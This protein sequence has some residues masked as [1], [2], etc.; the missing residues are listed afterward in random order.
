[1]A[2]AV[3][4][5]PS[6][7]VTDIPDDEVP[8]A[9]RVTLDSLVTRQHTLPVTHIPLEGDAEPPDEDALTPEQQ[10]AIREAALPPGTVPASAVPE[11]PLAEPPLF[12]PEVAVL[13]QRLALLEAELMGMRS[14]RGAEPTPVAPLPAPAPTADEIV[15]RVA[16]RLAPMFERV[17][18]MDAGTP[19]YQQER[20]RAFARAI[21]E[22]VAEDIMGYEG[23]Q[24]RFRSEAERIADARVQAA[25]AQ[26]RQNREQ[27]TTAA[28]VLT[29]ATQI[30]RDAGYDVYE[31]S[32][33]R[34][35]NSRESITYWALAS[36]L[37]QPGRSVAQEAQAALA[38]MGPK[39]PVVPPAAPAPVRPQPMGR[40]ANVP[41][42]ATPTATPAAEEE[43]TPVTLNQIIQAGMRQQRIGTPRG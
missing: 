9:Q 3:L 25:M 6:Q 29:Q 42:V 18:N 35:A 40:Q 12:A 17:E 30:A 21:H 7:F 38:I 10:A 37:S 22:A 32:D 19:T 2:E 34:H 36:A 4:V 24:Q 27:A 20:A 43:Y 11:P 13:Q 39:A 31:P 28:S 8:G 33:P 1:M 41:A 5:D 14:G 15:D 26:E 16:N 23:V